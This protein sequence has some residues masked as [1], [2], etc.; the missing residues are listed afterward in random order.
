M[1]NPQIRALSDAGDRHDE[2]VRVADAVDS[3]LGA[4]L[5]SLRPAV[6]ELEAA[7]TSDRATP[8]G[9]LLHGPVADTCRR[10]L[11]HGDDHLV[12]LTFLADPELVSNPRDR[13]VGWKRRA[14]GSLYPCL[15]GTDPTSAHYYEY[16]DLDWFARLHEG[17]D[18][19]VTGPYVD[20][21]GTDTYTVTMALRVRRLGDQF[22]GVLAGDLD[23]DRVCQDLTG[24]LRTTRFK[25]V[26]VDQEQRVVASTAADLPVGHRVPADGHAPAHTRVCPRTDWTLLLG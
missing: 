6:R 2:L 20:Y 23:A 5:D 17:R 10:H 8:S 25:A 9:A 3:A 7:L 19:W 21:G 14:D 18:A 13:V 11:E 16:V 24:V 22:F 4:V 12:G 1:T 15:H 26:V